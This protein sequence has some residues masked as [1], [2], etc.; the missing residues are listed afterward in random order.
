MIAQHNHH[1]DPF[2]WLRTTHVEDMKNYT[3]QGVKTKE[4][5]LCSSDSIGKTTLHPS[6]KY[7]LPVS[8]DGVDPELDFD[9]EGIFSTK[10]DEIIDRL[11]FQVA[12]RDTIIKQLKS[13]VMMQQKLL[14]ANCFSSE[15]KPLSEDK[16]TSI[17]ESD[18]REVINGFQQKLAERKKRREYLMQRRLKRINE[19]TGV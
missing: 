7:F 9:N 4:P 16:N 5:L 8:S 1:E 12:Q 3:C 19:L 15:E 17:E 11:T 6:L 18:S 13:L 2:K 10:K 14:V